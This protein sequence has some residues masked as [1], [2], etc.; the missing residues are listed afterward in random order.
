MVIVDYRSRSTGYFYLLKDLIKIFTNKSNLNIFAHKDIIF[1][2][3]KYILRKKTY[4]LPMGSFCK[5]KVLKKKYDFI[6][7]GE[8]LK[9]KLVIIFMI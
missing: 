9:K 4:H 6:H 3:S 5:Y 8:Y 1:Y 7:I 2:L